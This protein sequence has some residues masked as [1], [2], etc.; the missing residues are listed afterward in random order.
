[1]RDVASASDVQQQP[2][3]AY[4]QP[5]GSGIWGPLS[6]AKN[7][8][9]VCPNSGI[10]TILQA[11]IHAQQRLNQRRGRTIVVYRVY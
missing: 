5:H 6:P 7:P 3:A 10:E 4:L 1:M 9:I 11:Q 2:A 8:T